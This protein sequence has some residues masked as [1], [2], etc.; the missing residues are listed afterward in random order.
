M[1]PDLFCQHNT[2]AFYRFR[3][4]NGSYQVKELCVGCYQNVRGSLLVPHAE[5]SNLHTL[6]VLKDNL[7]PLTCER[8]GK[9]EGVEEHHWA[10]KALFADAEKWPTSSLCSVCHIYWHERMKH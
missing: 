2:T 5:I 8:C 1:T 3:I 6:P 9:I 10:P 7:S 4:A